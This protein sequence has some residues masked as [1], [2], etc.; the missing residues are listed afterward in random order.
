MMEGT[1]QAAKGENQSIV[2]S[3]YKAYVQNKNPGKISPV[4]Q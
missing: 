4:M 3:N 2:I 1:M